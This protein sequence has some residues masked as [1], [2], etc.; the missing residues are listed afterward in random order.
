ML[1]RSGRIDAAAECTSTKLERYAGLHQFCVIVSP[2][3]LSVRAGAL[4]V[5]LKVL[6]RGFCLEHC[7]GL[8]CRPV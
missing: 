7:P 1:N 8:R 3:F 5:H 6:A 4:L 2:L